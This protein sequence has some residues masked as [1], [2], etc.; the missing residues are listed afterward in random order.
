[1]VVGIGGVSRSGK[2]FLSHDVV[3]FYRQ[4]NLRAI[5]VRLDDYVKQI[6]EIPTIKGEIDW[7]IPAS[8]D[9]A[10]ALEALAFFKQKFDVV[11]VEGHL[12]YANEALENEFDT[13]FVL[14][15]DREMFNKR[16]END[17]RWGEVPAWYTE[18]IWNSFLE[19]GNPS[20]TNYVKIKTNYPTI[21]DIKIH[22]K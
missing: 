11:V 16:K 19:V 5:A 15:I 9:Y 18:Y 7:E 10:K 22:L 21:E 17:Q 12:I 2:T 4:K 6:N 1:M 20:G 13:K 8:I 3:W 14:E